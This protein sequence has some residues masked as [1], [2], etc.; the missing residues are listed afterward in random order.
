MLLHEGIEGIKEPGHGVA[1]DTA[2]RAGRRCLQADTR[3]TRSR[4]DDTCSSV[5]SQRAGL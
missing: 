5:A 4:P 1:E 2:G 3:I